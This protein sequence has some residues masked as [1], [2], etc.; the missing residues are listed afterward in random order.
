MVSDRDNHEFIVTDVELADSAGKDGVG[1][2]LTDRR[3]GRV[4]LNLTL[5]MAARLR[6]RISFALDRGEGS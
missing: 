6:E 1:V 3:G 4:R 5:D 2:I